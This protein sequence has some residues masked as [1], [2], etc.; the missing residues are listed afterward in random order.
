MKFFK[1]IG[2]LY[3]A[4]VEGSY[5]Q[6][7]ETKNV[8]RLQDGNLVKVLTDDVVIQCLNMFFNPQLWHV[9]KAHWYDYLPEQRILCWVRDYVQSD[10]VT[11]IITVYD[12]GFFTSLDGEQWRFA[13]PMSPEEINSMIFTGS[14]N[15]WA[16]LT[17]KKFLC[18]VSNDKPGAADYDPAVDVIVKHNKIFYSDDN[19]V[20]EYATPLTP[21][22][23]AEYTFKE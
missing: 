13:Q 10:P 5:I 15:W 3:Q 7:S 20:Y 19:S 18:W 1:N 4:L 17:K 8:L 6:H 12:N 22:E 2:Q 11:S 23:A 21:L 9:Y 16:K 14:G